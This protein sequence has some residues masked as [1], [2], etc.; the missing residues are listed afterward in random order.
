MNMFLDDVTITQK[1]GQQSHLKQVNP[2]LPSATLPRLSYAI[3]YTFVVGK[4]ALSSFPRSYGTVSMLN[5]FN[6]KQGARTSI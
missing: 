2:S 3:R 1:D 5:E 6:L 4:S